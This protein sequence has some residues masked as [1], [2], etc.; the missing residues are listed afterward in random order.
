MI[1]SLI[2]DIIKYQG[3]LGRFPRALRTALKPSGLH[4][5]PASYMVPGQIF[6][7]KIVKPLVGW[8]FGSFSWFFLK[9]R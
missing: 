2:C 4:F 7:W 8:F 6:G 3:C 5:P 1:F 9:R